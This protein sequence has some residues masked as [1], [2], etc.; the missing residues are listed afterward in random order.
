MNLSALIGFNI[1]S[2]PSLQA[3]MIEAATTASLVY[4]SSTHV[5]FPDDVRGVILLSAVSLTRHG[6]YYLIARI[7]SLHWFHL[8][9]Q[10]RD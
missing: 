10:M 2:N 8:I 1:A 6:K 9:P 4:V 7:H 5:L 3:G